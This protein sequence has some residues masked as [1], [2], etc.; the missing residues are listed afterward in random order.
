MAGIKSKYLITSF[1]HLLQFFRRLSLRIRTHL[2]GKANT[3]GQERFQRMARRVAEA[4]HVQVA[5]LY[6]IT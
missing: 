1:Q 4:A 3:D 2:T 5:I 6:I